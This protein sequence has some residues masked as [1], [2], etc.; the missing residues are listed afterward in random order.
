MPSRPPGGSSAR[1][2]ARYPMI[3]AHSRGAACR[4]SKRR[5]QRVDVLLVGQRVGRVAAVEVPAGEGRRDA[6]VLAAAAT[7][8]AGPARA[9]QPRRAHALAHA[10]ARDLG[11]ERVDDADDLVA[12]HDQGSS[13]RQVALGQVQVR[14]ADPAR[15]HPQAHLAG[16]GLGDLALD[17]H[18]RSRVDRSGAVHRPRGHRSAHGHLRHTPS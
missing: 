12:G 6:Q 3:P 16:G 11:S 4:S 5:G 13:R 2:S 18:Q 1:S 8:G 14:A 17:A 9:G 10:Q 15:A 7:E